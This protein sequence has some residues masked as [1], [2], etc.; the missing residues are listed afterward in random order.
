MEKDGKF[1]P[2]TEENQ[3]KWNK[4]GDY[5]VVWA[6]F[7]ERESQ[8]IETCFKGGSKTIVMLGGQMKSGEYEEGDQYYIEID[9]RCQIKANDK[10]AFRVIKRGREKSPVFKFTH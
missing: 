6:N 8:V 1:E 3:W 4:G 9:R 7:R 5:N 2:V 10:N